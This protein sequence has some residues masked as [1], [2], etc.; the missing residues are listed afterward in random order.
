MKY[1]EDISWKQTTLYTSQ[2]G[3]KQ[4]DLSMFYRV[5]C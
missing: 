5:A 2:S 4:V 1:P 3:T